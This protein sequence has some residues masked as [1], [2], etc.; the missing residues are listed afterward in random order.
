V[1]RVVWSSDA[2]SLITASR[3]GTSR[4]YVVDLDDLIVLAHNRVTRTLT[5]EECQKFL[6]TEQCP[7][8]T[9]LSDPWEPRS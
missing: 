4:V 5:T 3:D 2:R 7:V 1:Y 8:E 9:G 6:H